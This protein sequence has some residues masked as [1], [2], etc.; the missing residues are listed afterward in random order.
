MAGVLAA[1][2][3]GVKWGGR[4]DFRFH[5]I[6]AF[7]ILTAHAVVL[8]KQFDLIARNSAM[9]ERIMTDFSAQRGLRPDRIR[10]RALR[11]EDA[12]SQSSD[13]PH[14]DTTTNDADVDPSTKP[15]KQ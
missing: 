15:L 6:A 2:T 9:M 8:Y 3:G 12:T 13:R 5:L 11:R 7:I 14:L 1:A 10:T 4:E